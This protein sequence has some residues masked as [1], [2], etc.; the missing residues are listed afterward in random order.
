M[1]AQQQKIVMARRARNCD[2]DM[3]VACD[4]FFAPRR[5][6]YVAVLRVAMRPKEKISFL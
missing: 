5:H 2:M 6:K 4:C 3:N 1:I